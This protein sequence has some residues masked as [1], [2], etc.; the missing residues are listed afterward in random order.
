MRSFLRA[1]LL[2]PILWLVNRFSSHPDRAR[3][4]SALSKL[5]E[6]IEHDP[7]KKGFVIPFNSNT[8]RFIIFSDQHKGRK[9]GADDFMYAERNYLEALQ[10][11]HKNQ[12]HL[13]CLGDSEELWE[14]TILQVMKHNHPSFDAEKLFAKRSAFTKIVGNHD[15]DWE[16]DPL[17]PAYLKKIYDEPVPVLQ[18]VALQ[19]TVARKPLMILCTHGH[20]G[21]LQSDGNWFSKFFVTKIWAPLQAYLK[22]YPNTPAYDKNLKTEHNKIMYEWSKQ[23]NDLILITGHTHQPVFE[24][25][26]HYE[27]LQWLRRKALHELNPQWAE[28]LENELRWQHKEELAVTDDYLAIKPAYFNTGCC[29]FADGYITG[30]EIEGGDIRLVKWFDTK[31]QTQRTVLQE[32]KLEELVAEL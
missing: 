16:I 32:R 2:K 17:A 10:Y 7:G 19:T 31:G 6:T 28:A 20:Q 25:L 27:R 26:T 14:N 1:I 9:N 23:Q 21:D 4:F 22:I 11:Y 5:K 12:F 15:L 18:A 13:I 30:I 29:C 8:H 3:I 24:S